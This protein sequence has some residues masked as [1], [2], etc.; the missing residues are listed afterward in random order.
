[1]R[2]RRAAGVLYGRT[3]TSDVVDASA[4]LCA[5]ERDHHVDTSDPQDSAVL[6]PELPVVIV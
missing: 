2:W 6:D 3:G 1:M 5:R 4:A